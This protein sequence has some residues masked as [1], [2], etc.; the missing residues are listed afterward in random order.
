MT[1]GKNCEHK[2]ILVYNRFSLFISNEVNT[3]IICCMGPLINRA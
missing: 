2:V 1:E 3:H